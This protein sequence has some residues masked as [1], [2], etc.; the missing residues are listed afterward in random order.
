MMMAREQHVITGLEIDF[1]GTKSANEPF[2]VAAMGM[3]DDGKGDDPLRIYGKFHKN[4]PETPNGR[5]SE[6]AARLAGD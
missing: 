4:C 2:G 5:S 1:K 6:D 3:V